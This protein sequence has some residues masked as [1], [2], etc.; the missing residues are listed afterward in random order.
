MEKRK[1]LRS[2]FG[3]LPGSSWVKNSMMAYAAVARWAM[4]LL[5]GLLTLVVLPAQAATA[6]T[7]AP[8]TWNV[9]GLDSN[10]VN[11]GPNDFP[12][13]ARVCNT[14]GSATTATVNFNWTSA[15]AYINLR[16]G[17]LSSLSLPLNAGQCKDTYFEVAVTRNAAAYDTTRDYTI[18]ATD[19]SGTASTPVPRQIY[20][21]H[22]VSQGRNATLNMQLSTDGGSTYTSVP[23]GGAMN[24]M[25]G[26]TYFIKLIAETAT[27]GYEQSES[28]I[29]FPNTIFQVLSVSTAYTADSS[30][31]VNNPN[32]K[33]YGDACLWDSNPASPNYRSC[34]STGKVGGSIV[35]TYQVKILS[36]PSAPLINPEP[37][38][39]LIYDFSGSS[40]HYNSDFSAS[41]RSADIVNATVAKSFA[42]KTITPGG[43]STLT[44]T[45]N[46]P[47]PQAISNVNFTDSLPFG[48]TVSGTS[49]TYSGCGTPSP[50]SLTNG[51]TALSFSSITVN[52][53]S[54]CTVSLSV[55]ATTAQ[56]YT[57]TTSTLKIGTDDTGSMGSDS[58]V[59]STK[60]AA[61]TSCTTPT[62][63]ATWDL[64]NYTASA[65]T[66]NGPFSSSSKQVDV[67]AATGTYGSATGSSSGIA[68]SITYPTG[69]PAPSS[70]TNN[71]WGINGGWLSTNPGSP[72]TAITPYYQFAV[73]ASNYGAI[74][75]SASYNLQGNWSNSGNWYVLFS[76]DGSTWSNPH[77]VTWDKSSGWK[78]NAITAS[79]TTSPNTTV[80]FRI[81]FA[82]A[83]YSGNP[84]KTTATAYLDDITISGCP[85]PT[86][87]TLSKSF[88][89]TN[90]VQ[91]STSTLAFNI[92]NPN[93]GIALSGISFTDVLPAGLSV[94][95]GTASACGGTVTTTASTHTIS[96]TGA[97]LAASGTCSF[98]VT[99]TGSTT[100]NHTNTS[101]SIT[102]TESGPNTTSSGYGVSNL[103]VVTPPV[104]AK[105]FGTTTLYTNG[106]PSSTSLTFS[107]TNPNTFTS[108]TG[109]NF[110]DSLPTGL[111]VDN[112]SGSPISPNCTTG[113]MTGQTITASNNAPSIGLSGATLTAGASC[114]FS[115]NVKV[116]GTTPVG[117]ATNSVTVSS[118]GP[119]AT[120][121]NTA[122]ATVNVKTVTPNISILK[123]VSTDN[124]NWFNSVNVTPGALRCITGSRWRIP[125]MWL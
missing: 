23:S 104:I 68:S 84:S 91:G 5:L 18:T 110:T 111:Q 1:L 125:A 31:Y 107:L 21:E 57:N 69:W 44:F 20:V 75:I 27:S 85:R 12:V 29:N 6:L 22:L 122:T 13:G 124:T 10:N 99:V 28:F 106:I 103:T 83:Q 63:M 59:V 90:I 36:V 37:L 45:I 30:T 81:F 56:T 26:Q 9:V 33:L 64:S 93:T 78:V 48:M 7:V 2:N 89:P 51:T 55:T 17:T 116:S 39:A 119:I 82:G 74:G 80:Y 70:G 67:S 95:D 113:S 11:V 38:N 60:P 121:G 25:V 54:T 105:T 109:V 3:G 115:V 53:L 118:S 73:D 97:S 35:T 87:P 19:G 117:S 100:G 8:I 114:T 43:T 120:T 34:L 65:S 16:P 108:L 86:P 76:T 50:S 79:T 88:S 98:N 77:S 94:A 102:A 46:N 101:G 71:F 58:L 41:V 66:N 112:P 32:D 42:P 14:S 15:N 40:Y 4:W 24:L 61:P 96:L 62:T 123:Q 92:T 52:A 47:G 49:L 72:T